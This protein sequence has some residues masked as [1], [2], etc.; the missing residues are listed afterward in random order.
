MINNKIS[1]LE[2]NIKENFDNEFKGL[3]IIEYKENIFIK[4]F[5]SIKDFIKNII[6]K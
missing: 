1:L 5:K 4:I 3:G 6:N 2:N